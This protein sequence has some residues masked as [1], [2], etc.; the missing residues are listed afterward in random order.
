MIAPHFRDSLRHILPQPNTFRTT[1][2]F[3][4]FGDDPFHLRQQPPATDNPR[5]S[6]IFLIKPKGSIY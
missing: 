4:R 3:Q 1:L 2:C 5:A 6:I